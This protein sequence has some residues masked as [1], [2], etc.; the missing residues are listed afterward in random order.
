[1]IPVIRS[2]STSLSEPIQMKSASCLSLVKPS[3]IQSRSVRA[4]PK[5]N[6]NVWVTRGQIRQVGDAV[7]LALREF[8]TSFQ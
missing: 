6:P 5:S 8:D 4:K 2:E 1:V 7:V 3:R